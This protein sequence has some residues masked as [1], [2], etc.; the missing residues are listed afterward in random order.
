LIEESKDLLEEEAIVA[1]P[2]QVHHHRVLVHRVVVAQD[3]I[4]VLKGDMIDLVISE[5]RNKKVAF[6]YAIKSKFLF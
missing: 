3:Q 4:L 6:L 2:I 5:I 1:V